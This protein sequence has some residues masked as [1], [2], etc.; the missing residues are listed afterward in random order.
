VATP[1]RGPSHS[2]PLQVQAAHF[3]ATST[4]P[5]VSTPLKATATAPT[6]APLPIPAPTP[7]P[8]PATPLNADVSAAPTPQSTSVVADTSIA[9]IS[10]DHA[11]TLRSRHAVTPGLLD[12]TVRLATPSTLPPGVRRET[13]PL[14]VGSQPAPSISSVAA[15]VAE[16]GPALAAHPTTKRAKR[17]CPLPPGLVNGLLAS[18]SPLHFTVEAKAAAHAAL[19]EFFPQIAEDLDSYVPMRAACWRWCECGEPRRL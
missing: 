4:A 12:A 8:A 10:R 5:A 19:A 7:T 14:F 6:V 17:V 13:R 15:A 16:P 1:A 9:S 2:T 3:Q 18:F 11:I